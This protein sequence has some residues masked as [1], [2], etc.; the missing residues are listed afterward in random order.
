MKTKTPACVNSVF[1][2]V[3][4]GNSSNVFLSRCRVVSLPTSSSCLADTD[5]RR[6]R[7]HAQ[8]ETLLLIG[9]FL[10]AAFRLGQTVGRGPKSTYLVF[11]CGPLLRLTLLLLCSL[12]KYFVKMWILCWNFIRIE[13][14]WWGNKLLK[15]SFA[16]I[17]WLSVISFSFNYVEIHLIL[18]EIQIFL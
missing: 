13:S 12:S 18:T 5:Q 2:A 11:Y 8:R 3:I 9:R 16:Q 7:G 15:E 14:N 6:G 17:T 10:L 4:E 1:F